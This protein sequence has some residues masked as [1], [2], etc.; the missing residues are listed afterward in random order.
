[1]MGCNILKL[2]SNKVIQRYYNCFLEF[3][4]FDFWKKQ[5]LQLYRKLV[6]FSK[7]MQGILGIKP[8]PRILQSTH[9]V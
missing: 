3:S 5:F 9:F 4:H 7:K 6:K 8:N 2:M 1:M